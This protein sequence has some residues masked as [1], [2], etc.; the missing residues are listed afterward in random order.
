MAYKT[1]RTVLQLLF[2]VLFMVGL[3]TAALGMI[4]AGFWPPVWFLMPF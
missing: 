4:A 3:V 1:H 2:A